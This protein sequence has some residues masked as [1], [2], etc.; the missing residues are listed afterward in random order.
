MANPKE[1]NKDRLQT[2]TSALRDVVV[3]AANSYRRTL[4]SDINMVEMGVFEEESEKLRELAL[5]SGNYAD[6]IAIVEHNTGK[7]FISEA[8]SHTGSQ[9]SAKLKI[10]INA[11][12]MTRQRNARQD[13]S[14]GLIA[15]TAKNDFD[16]LALVAS[17]LIEEREPL[18]P[19]GIMIVGQEGTHLFFRSSNTIE[20]TIKQNNDLIVQARGT[21]IKDFAKW[22]QLKHFYCPKGKTTATPVLM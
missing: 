21:S 15:S 16:N 14:I 5:K 4:P 13:R 22:N 6:F 11:L 20:Q 19:A 7:L 1:S 17:L 10:K 12:A 18:S 8:K 3:R 9:V 2:A